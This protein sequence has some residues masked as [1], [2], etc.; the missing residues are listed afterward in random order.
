MTFWRRPRARRRGYRRPAPSS[1]V[2]RAL[3][4]KACATADLGPESRSA[5]PV[6]RVPSAAVR[7]ALGPGVAHREPCGSGSPVPGGRC[8]RRS[9][10]CRSRRCRGRGT[11]RRPQPPARES[12][13]PR[14][15]ARACRGPNSGGDGPR[16]TGEPRGR[17]AVRAEHEV[18]VPRATPP[19]GHGSSAG[20][21]RP[22]FE[23]CPRRRLPSSSSPPPPNWR[24][25]AGATR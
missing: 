20:P 13:W 19:G 15:A 10:G 22:G 14:I 4:T 7:L 1:G 5:T 17:G 21:V 6:R 9:P 8:G 3:R 12:R 23:P 25:S 18:P 16:H 2:R 11:R 24:M